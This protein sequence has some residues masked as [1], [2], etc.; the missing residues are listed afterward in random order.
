MDVLPV[1][2]PDLRPLVPWT[3]AALRLLILMI[4]IVGLSTETIDYAFAG[5]E[6]TRHYCS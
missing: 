3:E 1:L 4:F 6:R 5:S 2:P